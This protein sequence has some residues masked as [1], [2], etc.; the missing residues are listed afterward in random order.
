MED[1]ARSTN[2]Q[3]T[4]S[5]G[6]MVAG[7]EL[8]LQA[9]IKKC[10]E[11][12]KQKGPACMVSANPFKNKV[13]Y[14]FIVANDM[15]AVPVGPMI[16]ERCFSEFSNI[17]WGLIVIC[18]DDFEGIG[19][20]FDKLRHLREFHSSAPV[21]LTSFGFKSHDLTEERLVICDSSIR[22]PLD[23]KMLEEI[24]L[25]AWQ[26]NKRWRERLTTVKYEDFPSLNELDQPR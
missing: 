3:N 8:A 6:V 20:I 23:E 11:S 13:L 22:F 12:W 17:D 19:P 4:A 16:F 26:N 18:I 5:P 24:F 25:S 1:F 14:D 15:S 7:C 21:L 9:D 10:F 2:D